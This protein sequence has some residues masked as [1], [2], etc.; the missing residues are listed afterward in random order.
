MAVKA[1]Y[2]TRINEERRSFELPFD[3]EGD[4]VL[5]VIIIGGSTGARDGVGMTGEAEGAGFD[6]VPLTVVGPEVGPGVVCVLVGSEVDCTAVGSGVDPGVDGISVGSDV[7]SGVDGIAVGSDADSA[8]DG[9]AVG[10]AVGEGSGACPLLSQTTLKPAP[11]GLSLEHSPGIPPTHASDSQESLLSPTGYTPPLG[12]VQ[13]PP[14]SPTSG[15][16][17]KT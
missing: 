11:P 16:P 4:A 7:D 1:M 6:G 14:Q 8:V 15:H 5:N 17:T 9:V 2:T 10:P 12:H 3:C 13:V